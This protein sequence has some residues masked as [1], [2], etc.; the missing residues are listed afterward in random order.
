[1]KR[2]A[3]QTTTATLADLARA[4]GRRQPVTIT[5]LKEEKGPTGRK[6]GRLVETVRTI[7]I[8]DTDTTKAGNRI[9]K[10]MDRQ[11]GEPRTFRVDRIQ[12]YTVHRTGYTLRVKESRGTTIEVVAVNTP[13]PVECRGIA[14]E[15]RDYW[16]DRYDQT[17]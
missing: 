5:Y 4:Q 17:A 12:A 9:L 15:D 13:S 11:S 7:E 14:R 8:Y 10:A 2:T 16:N 1:M 6:T 3:R